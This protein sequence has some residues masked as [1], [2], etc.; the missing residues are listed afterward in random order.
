MA[1]KQL[2][3]ADVM[4][5]K[6]L[7]QAVYN[8]DGQLLLN[9]GSVLRD[10][11]AK[12]KLLAM[13]HKEVVPGA[14]PV[15]PAPVAPRAEQ[16]REPV[17][18]LV[19]H[20]AVTLNAMLVDQQADVHRDQFIA[21]IRSLAGRLQAACQQDPEAAIAAIHLFHEG[22]YALRH[23]LSVGVVSALLAE[24]DGR[25][26]KAQ[27]HSLICAALTH[28]IGIYSLANH[29]GGLTEEKRREINQHPITSCAILK[30][31]GVDDEL[32]LEAV[33]QHHERQDGSGYPLSLS[34]GAI[35]LHGSLLAVADVYCA[36]TRPRP[37]RPKAYFPMA[38]MRDLYVG[39]SQQLDNALIQKLIKALGLI[40]PGTI[41]KLKNGEIA[42]VK[43]R[44]TNNAPQA[45]CLYNRQ[46][47]PMASP[48]A[49]NT[50]LPDYAIQGRVDYD[51]CRN[52]EAAM[53]RIWA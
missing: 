24:A 51:D 11:G 10:P 5:G 48:D 7:E 49:R 37:Y 19:Q 45:F 14:A 8:A 26:D 6:P 35:S 46:G 36:M 12:Q 18:A 4:L 13:G 40:P 38:A 2:S 43:K 39:Q 17:F 42:V 52:V 50:A 1:L 33:L 28:D 23:H 31:I 53:R 15:A 32:W 44:S 34:G 29:S 30:D 3:P 27:Q 41:V 47:M 16:L 21:R 22:E 20:A 9:K 25:L